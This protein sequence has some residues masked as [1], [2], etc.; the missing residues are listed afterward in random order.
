MKTINYEIHRLT[1]MC[2]SGRRHSSPHSLSVHYMTVTESR[3]GFLPSRNLFL[4]IISDKAAALWGGRDPGPP[5]NPGGRVGG[6]SALILPADPFCSSVYWIQEA[7]IL[8]SIS[9]QSRRD[10]ISSTLD[11]L[12][13]MAR[14][15]LNSRSSVEVQ[16]DNCSNVQMCCILVHVRIC[17]VLTPRKKCIS[18][19]SDAGNSYAT[20]G[21]LSWCHV[22]LEMCWLVVKLS[23]NYTSVAGR[24]ERG[25]SSSTSA[26]SL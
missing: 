10:W 5:G 26:L 22:V 15:L 18:W 11:Q 2:R 16:C 23:S 3:R 7:A 8:D 21:I 25:K 6:R 20:D 4:E 14:E 17:P 1:V 9:T 19:I 24:S 13:P 12:L